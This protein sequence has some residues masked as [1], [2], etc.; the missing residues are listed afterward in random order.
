MKLKNILK[1]ISLKMISA[2][3]ILYNKFLKTKKV[4]LV[5]MMMDLSTI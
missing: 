3:V 5:I 2:M 4:F 1:K